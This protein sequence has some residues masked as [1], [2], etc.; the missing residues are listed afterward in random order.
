LRIHYVLIDFESVQ[1]TS[2]AALEE[3]PYRVLVFVGTTQS[4]LSF[5]VVS[6]IQRMGDRARY[7]KMSGAGPNALDFHIAF[8]IGELAAGDPTAFFH[9]ISKDTGFDPLIKHLKERHISA[10]RLASIEEMPQVRA[11]A[12]GLAQERAR[13]FAEA[14]RQPKATKPR[15]E[16]TLGRHIAAFF[17]KQ[18]LSEVEIESVVASMIADGHIRIADG[19]VA[20][21][22]AQ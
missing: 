8:Y 20:Y 13:V 7:M 16:K 21:V 10:R 6:S 12:K 17:Q 5:D 9:I 18:K 2:L 1:P 19:K 3:D 4:K 22:L 11:T 15:T 14:L